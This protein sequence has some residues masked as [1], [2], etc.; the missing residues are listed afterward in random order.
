MAKPIVT[1]TPSRV[2]L[3]PGNTWAKMSDGSWIQVPT[4]QAAFRGGMPQL[5]VPMDEMVDFLWQ[6]LYDTVHLEMG[7]PVR[8]ELNF[9]HVPVGQEARFGNNNTRTYQKPK[10][11]TN[12]TDSRRLPKGKDMLIVG[13]CVDVNLVD[14][15]THALVS[16]SIGSHAEALGGPAGTNNFPAISSPT[17]LMQA[18]QNTMVVENNFGADKTYE[19]GKVK[20]F[21]SPFG[22]SGFAGGNVQPA[23][24]TGDGLS[25]TTTNAT[26]E[27]I[28]QNGFGSYQPLA[29]MRYLRA[30]ESF[31]TIIKPC[32]PFVPNMHFQVEVTYL[33]Y[34]RRQVQ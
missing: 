22:S 31:D 29:T 9:F 4:M 13:I 7:V 27:V 3:A 20:H 17:R 28:V 14:G 15:H 21:P 19:T 1:N 10:C 12:L 26:R 16:S 8:E 5:S 32:V 11:D 33:G 18:I 25:A 24:L 30:G 34:L 2:P 6:P 23:D